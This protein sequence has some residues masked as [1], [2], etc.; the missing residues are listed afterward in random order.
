MKYVHAVA[1]V[2]ISYLTIHL[3]YVDICMAIS[4]AGIHM[5]VIMQII[6]V[7]CCK[8]VVA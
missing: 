7:Q 2:I 1:E 5:A 8:N 3:V 4:Y 6:S